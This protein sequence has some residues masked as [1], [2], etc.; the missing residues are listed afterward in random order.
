MEPAASDGRVV[1]IA[2]G[3]SVAITVPV[4]VGYDECLLDRRRRASSVPSSPV[5][6]NGGRVKGVAEGWIR[7]LIQLLGSIGV[8][9][10]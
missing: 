3:R 7:P 2:P 5:G 8:D 9:R 1:D 6:Y 4:V 10:R